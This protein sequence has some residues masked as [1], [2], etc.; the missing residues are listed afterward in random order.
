MVLLAQGL[1]AHLRLPNPLPRPAQRLRRSGRVGGEERTLPLKKRLH[2]GRF[3]RAEHGLKVAQVLA[4]WS[5]V[6]LV[7]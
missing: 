6:E 3:Q 4:R 1:L 2:N 7:G 5:K